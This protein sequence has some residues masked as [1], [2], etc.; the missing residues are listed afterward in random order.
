[1][2]TL[3]QEFCELVQHRDLPDELWAMVLTL[4]MKV[5]IKSARLACKRFDRLTIP[6]L[7]NVVIVAPHHKDLEVFDAIAGHEVYSKC[8]KQLVY[9]AAEFKHFALEEYEA[10]LRYQ[11]YEEDETHMLTEAVIKQGYMVHQ[12]H[13]TEQAEILNDHEDFAHL[14]LNLRSFERLE[15]FTVDD[16]WFEGLSEDEERFD[17]SVMDQP[18]KSH[19][20]VQRHW[21][22]LHLEPRSPDRITLQ[23]ALMTVV[24][25]LAITQT[26]VKEIIS[27]KCMPHSFL[28]TATVS[29]ATTVH[30]IQVFQHLRKLVLA[31]NSGGSSVNLRNFAKVLSAAARLED[32]CLRFN[33]P[34]YPEPCTVSIGVI[35]GHQTWLR[36]KALEL[37]GF[38][39]RF[40]ELQGVLHRHAETLR[41]LI[42]WYC[43]LQDGNWTNVV[44]FLRSDL[45]LSRF[46]ITEVRDPEG[47]EVPNHLL[48]S[49]KLNEYVCHGGENPLREASLGLLLR[50]GV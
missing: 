27:F 18:P 49:Q 30:A 1:M 9:S 17:R 36:L 25:A 19:G 38:S 4:L 40:A 23:Q 39:F 6:L 26:R 28:M 37:Q 15:R 44:D 5:D 11:F 24:R 2:E 34:M 33:V 12:I 13:A 20:Y 46:G 8:V 29:N 3:L 50:H 10:G 41:L 47:K 45:K 43:D 42:L 35:F 32:L 31:F 48:D 21:N 16:T 22:P 7:Y 14:C